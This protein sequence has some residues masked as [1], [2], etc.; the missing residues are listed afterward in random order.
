MVII[1][2]SDQFEQDRFDPYKQFAWEFETATA[3]TENKETL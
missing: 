1:V 2:Y 3:R